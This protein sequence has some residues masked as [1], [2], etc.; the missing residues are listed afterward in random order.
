M[1]RQTYGIIQVNEH[2]TFMYGD[3]CSTYTY[4]YI[5]LLH[6]LYLEGCCS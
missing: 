2:T 4:L 3:V 6:D 1:K 5:I